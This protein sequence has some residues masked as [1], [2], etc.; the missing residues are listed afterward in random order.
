MSDYDGMFPPED[1]I[2]ARG[3]VWYTLVQ[4]LEA[5]NDIENDET[6]ICFNDI[7]DYDDDDDDNDVQCE[8][9]NIDS[10]N[11]D[12]HFLDENKDKIIQLVD[13]KKKFFTEKGLFETLNFQGMNWIQSKISQSFLGSGSFGQT[14]YSQHHEF[15]IFTFSNSSQMSF[16]NSSLMQQAP[17]NFFNPILR[18]NSMQTIYGMPP[19][20]QP[21]LEPKPRS[22]S[23]NSF[24]ENYKNPN[25]RAIED[26]VK[27]SS[28]QNKKNYPTSSS[29]DERSDQ[30]RSRFKK[31]KRNH[32]PIRKIIPKPKFKTI[33]ISSESESDFINET[34]KS[35]KS[36]NSMSVAPK[37]QLNSDPDKTL[38]KED[39]LPSQ[40]HHKTASGEFLFYL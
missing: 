34:L 2:K 32:Q 3:D 8:E 27:C 4:R 20:G 1:E 26:V 19:M 30:Q 11:D 31:V 35:R 28:L 6:D 29:S 18:T 15:S 23:T 21:Q 38:T 40:R 10:D 25:I 5:L 22:I 7:L 9:T 24:A 17:A 33:I 12:D 16:S 14:S 13:Q 37:I 36:Q 39:V